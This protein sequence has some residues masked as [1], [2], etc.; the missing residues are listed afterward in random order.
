M[1]KYIEKT[2]QMGQNVNNSR[3]LCQSQLKNFSK[4]YP[5][6]HMAHCNIYT[7]INVINQLDTTS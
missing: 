5:Q 3:L 4:V 7:F 1:Y 2:K 6:Y